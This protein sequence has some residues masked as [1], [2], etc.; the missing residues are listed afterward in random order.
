MCF[1]TCI[2][3]SCTLYSGRPTIETTIIIITNASNISVGPVGS[4]GSFMYSP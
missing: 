3:G 1:G 2:I 4:S